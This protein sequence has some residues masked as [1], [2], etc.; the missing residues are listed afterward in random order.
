[1]DCPN[2]SSITVSLQL[3]FKF[4]MQLG[5]S[6]SAAKFVAIHIL[7]APHL[8]AKLPLAAT[9][10]LLQPNVIAHSFEALKGL[11]GRVHMSFP[12]SISNQN[13]AM[14]ID[15]G[16]IL[17]KLL[18]VCSGDLQSVRMPALTE[19]LGCGGSLISQ[20]LSLADWTPKED[21]R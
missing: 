12:L 8:T 5:A 15:V 16:T 14:F 9:A 4:V 2:G 19:I 3:M 6:D 13:Q 7:T 17:A 11:A 1:M 20:S 18:T 21:P 10:C